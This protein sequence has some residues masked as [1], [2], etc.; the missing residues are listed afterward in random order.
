MHNTDPNVCPRVGHTGTTPTTHIQLRT[1]FIFSTLILSTYLVLQLLTTFIAVTI[2]NLSPEENMGDLVALGVTF[3]AIPSTALVILIS[4]RLKKIKFQDWL[5]LV[6]V[7]ATTLLGWT[8][9]AYGL[10]LL[11]D[12]ITL[13]LGRPPLPPIMRVMSETTRFYNLLLF[14]LVIAA[15]IFE[16]VFFRGF[17][18]T[19]LRQ[20]KLGPSGTIIITTLL[21]TILHITQYD[22][23][24]LTIVCL[25]GILLGVAREHSGSIYIPLAIHIL[26]NLLGSL[27]MSEAKITSILTLI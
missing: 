15:P 17:L 2:M 26:N 7:R 27:Q 22:L 3:S 19:G 13:E 9:C 4:N 16:E 10:L 23:Y 1:I 20:K 5:G 21:W 8:V 24:Y 14:G 6:P 25:I 11:G 18:F 12:F